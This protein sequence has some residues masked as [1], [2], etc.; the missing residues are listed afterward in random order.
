MTAIQDLISRL[1]KAEGPSRELEAAIALATGW[2]VYV[3]DNWIGPHGEIAVPNYTGSLDAAIRLGA[4]LGAAP[5]YV[6]WPALTG[7]GTH[8]TTDQIA[9]RGVCA[10]L[11]AIEAKE[12]QS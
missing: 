1:E 7:G 9:R 12:P 6:L 4:H 5:P 2:S 3:G 11:R 8:A 10:L